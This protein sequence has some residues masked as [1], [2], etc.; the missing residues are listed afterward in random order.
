M[1][2][3]NKKVQSWLSGK[4]GKWETQKLEV[5]GLVLKERSTRAWARVIDRSG[6]LERPLAVGTSET[7]P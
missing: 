4:R 6:H 7:P 3:R 5:Q 2:L 1:L